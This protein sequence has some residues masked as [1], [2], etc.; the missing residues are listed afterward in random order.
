MKLSIW[1][2]VIASLRLTATLTELILFRLDFRMLVFPPPSVIPASPSN[3]PALQLN[4][5]ASRILLES[6]AKPSLTCF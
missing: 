3:L 1:Y 4:M 5:R 6:M 2:E